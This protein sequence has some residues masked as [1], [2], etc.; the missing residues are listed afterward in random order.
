MPN[1][2]E[3]LSLA[4]DFAGTCFDSGKNAFDVEAEQKVFAEYDAKVTISVDWPQPA[5]D[6]C[7]E[8]CRAL[9]KAQFED[10]A[11]RIVQATEQAVKKY[12]RNRMAQQLRN[13]DAVKDLLD[14]L[15]EEKS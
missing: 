10:D 3:L 13:R 5:A 6:E 9:I 7:E 14:T 15:A 1:I 8:K 11:E 4:A 2:V 12:L